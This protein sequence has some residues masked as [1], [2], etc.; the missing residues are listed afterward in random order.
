MLDV[1]VDL[2]IEYKLPNQLTDNPSLLLHFSLLAALKR[3]F[4]S[5]WVCGSYPRLSVV[6]CVVEVKTSIAASR[7]EAEFQA[8]VG[9]VCMIQARMEL[10]D[11]IKKL[12]NDAVLLSDSSHKVDKTLLDFNFPVVTLV[13]MGDT[14]YYQVVYLR[15]MSDCVCCPQS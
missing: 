4:G 1:K 14:W 6:A 5:T 15:K 12:A 3:A 8:A 7:L 11:E 2:S 9:G 13:I 10:V